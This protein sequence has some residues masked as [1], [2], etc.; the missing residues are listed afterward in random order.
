MGWGGGVPKSL[1]NGP[2]FVNCPPPPQVD[3]VLLNDGDLEQ[4]DAR[5]DEMEGVVW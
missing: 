2:G 3:A 1:I 4:L 5:V